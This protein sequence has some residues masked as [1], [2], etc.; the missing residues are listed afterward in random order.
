MITPKISAV[1]PVITEEIADKLIHFL[2]KYYEKLGVRKY[3]AYKGPA[4]GKQK[5]FRVVGAVEYHQPLP[6]NAEEHLEKELNAA[7]KLKG[8]HFVVFEDSGHYGINY[9]ILLSRIV[10]K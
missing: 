8:K 3:R 7:I 10:K 5:G 9:E 6:F 1:R 4:L 2:H